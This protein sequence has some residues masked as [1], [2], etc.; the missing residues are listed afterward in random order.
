[1]SNGKYK[2]VIHRAS[3]SNGATRMSMATVIAPSLDTL[4]EPAS[5]LIDNEHNP[6]AYVG[7]RHIDYMELQ[8]SNQLYRKSVLQSKNLILSLKVKVCNKIVKYSKR[9]ESSLSKVLYTIL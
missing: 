9:I 6:P 5:E 3:V 2:S 1:M 7:M 8:R 4:V